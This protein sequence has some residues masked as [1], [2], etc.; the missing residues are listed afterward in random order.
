YRDNVEPLSSD[1]FEDHTPLFRSGECVQS[2]DDNR[3][4]LVNAYERNQDARR[5]CI[6]H[7]GLSCRVCEVNFGAVYGSLGEGYIHVHHIKPIHL[8]G[9]EYE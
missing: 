7:F 5:A 6:S 8:C 3:S 1:T 4:V 9:G 2:L